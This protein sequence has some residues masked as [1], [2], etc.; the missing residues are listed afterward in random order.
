MRLEAEVGEAEARTES[1]GFGAPSASEKKLSST[2]RASN[3]AVAGAGGAIASSQWKKSAA[4]AFQESHAPTQGDR[5]IARRARSRLALVRRNVASAR[6]QG[7]ARLRSG[8]RRRHRDR[9][10]R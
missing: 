4:T 10:R 7:R 2:S 3:R 9:R 8:D 5:S 1:P 6:A